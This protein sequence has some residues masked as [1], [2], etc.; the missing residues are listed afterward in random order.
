MQKSLPLPGSRFGLGLSVLLALSGWGL[1]A[2][3]AQP[4]LK[5]DPG[6]IPPNLRPLQ[7]EGAIGM[8]TKDNAYASLTQAFLAAQYAVEP[9]LGTRG[10]NGSAAFAASNPA[11]S[12]HATFTAEEV[13]VR[14][15]GARTWEVHFKLRGYGYGG[16]L[17]DLVGGATRGRENRIELDKHG[18]SDGA[19]VA[20][21]EWYEN[22]PSGLEQGFT[23]LAPPRSRAH[24]PGHLR[25]VLS[26]T[27]DLKP[28]VNGETRSLKLK[29]RAG[30]VLASYNHLKAWD[31]TGRELP[32]QMEVKGS[33]VSL[34]V[35]DASAKYP[36]T[37]DPTLEP[38]IKL[39]AP[40]SITSNQLGFAVAIS[41]S[42]AVIG[43]PNQNVGVQSH[44][45]MAYVF[46]RDGTGW[47]LQQ[48]L[49]AF[50]VTNDG[51]TTYY[52]GN[53]VG[54]SGNTIVVGSLVGTDATHF[55]ILHGEAHI[56]DR[57]GNH[58]S[59]RQKL[60]ADD[61]AGHDTFGESVAIT[62]DTVIIGSS[63]S[64]SAGDGS[65]EY[66][67]AA[68]IFGRDGEQWSKQ[69]KL[70]AS[71]GAKLDRF[72]Y[73]VSVSG[74]TA[75]VGA[76]NAG[77]GAAY[78]YGRSGVSWTQKKKLVPISQGAD[79]FGLSVGISG[80]NIFVGAPG[81]KVGQKTNQGAAYVSTRT[82]FVW[83]EPKQLLA[84]DGVAGDAFGESVAISGGTA[85]IGA[86]LKY[87]GGR[88]N[89]G[90]AY[91]YQQSSTG[92]VPVQEM[93]A[94]DGNTYQ[95][96]GQAVAVSGETLLIGAPGD[97][98]A[99][100]AAYIYETLDSDGDGIPDA[101]EINGITVGA[102]GNVVGL[103][104]LAGQGTFIDLKAMGADPMHKDIFV[105]ADWMHAASGS[106]TFKP[107]IKTMKVVTAAFAKAPVS[108]PDGRT[109]INLHVDLGAD[110]EMRPGQNW[111]SLSRAGEEPYVATLGSFTSDGGNPPVQVY[112]WSAFDGM[113]TD[114]F[115][116]SGR[117]AVFHYV[118]FANNY[119]GAKRSGGIARE[120]PSADI[121]VAMGQASGATVMQLGGTFMHELGHNLG[122]LHGGD[123]ETNFKPN[124][125]SIMN[126]TFQL[127][128]LVRSKNEQHVMDYSRR[129]LPILNEN[130]LDENVGIGEPAF[131]TFWVKPELNPGDF[132]YRLFQNG[133]LDWN[134]DGVQNVA[135]VSVD[136]TGDGNETLV[137]GFEDW[138]ALR[139]DG[140]GRIGNS[141]GADLGDRAATRMDEA[142]LTEVQAIV[143]PRI[144]NAEA[145]APD[146]EATIT[147]QEGPNSLTVTF[148]GSASTAVN[149]TIVSWAWDFGDGTTGTG[150]V[151]QHTY[152]SAGDYFATLTVTDSNGKINVIVLSYLVTVHLPP[153]PTPTPT[154]SPTPVPPPGPGQVDSTFMA[155]V[156]SYGGRTFNGNT[157]NAVITQPDGKIIVGGAFESFAGRARRNIARINAD[158]S[159]DPT[160]NPGLVLTDVLSSNKSPDVE[161]RN[162]LQ[163]HALKL[164]PDGKILVGVSGVQG[165]RAGVLYASKTLFRLNADG[166]LDPS[167]DAS[168]SLTYPNVIVL[169]I[170]LQTDGKIIIGGSFT[171]TNNGTRYDI[172]RLNADG[173]LDTSFMGGLG[174]LR[175]TADFA[176]DTYQ[177][178]AVQPD[179]KIIV[180]GHFFSDPN[181]HPGY[182]ATPILRINSNG[183]LDTTFNANRND[184]GTGTCGPFD[185]V[186]STINGL[187]LQSDGKIIAAGNLIS[188][189]RTSSSP[190]GRFNSDGS[191]D[192]LANG[193][194][195]NG[196]SGPGVG[197]ALQPD[198]KVIVVGSF[199]FGEPAT[200]I[201]VARLNADFTLDTSYNAGTGTLAPP[202]S[203]QRIQ[204]SVLAVA[205]QANGKAVI[206]GIFD[207]F[208]GALTEGIMQINPDGS[209]DQGFDSN[210]P[211]INAEVSALVRQPDG[212]LLVGF[213]GSS[214]GSNGDTPRNKLNSTRLGAIGRL[215][216]DGTTDTT[217][218]PPFDTGSG[219]S[220]IALQSDGKIVISGSFR[221]VGDTTTEGTFYLT[222]LNSNGTLDATFHPPPT[223]VPGRAVIRPDG[224]ILIYTPNG[225]PGLIRLNV[226]GS[227]D[228]TFSTEFFPNG[229]APMALQPDG[230]I[231][232][233]VAGRNFAPPHIGRLNADG[234]VDGTFDSGTGPDNA[235]RSLVL[236]PDGKI[237][238][239]GDFFNYN[240]TP[241][242]CMARLNADGSLD[243]S[244]IPDNPN[245]A[246]TNPTVPERVGA[247]ALQSD[248]KIFVGSYYRGDAF[249][250]SPN[251]IFR[252]N[253]NGSLD[254]S[255]PLGTGLEGQNLNVNAILL[256]QDGQ[257][258]IGG[259]FNIVNGAAHLALA[260]FIGA[261]PTVLANISTR[262]R[263]EAGDNALIGGFIITGTGQKKVLLRA[264]GPSLP[265]AGH[266]EDPVLELFAAN[267]QSIARNDNW[268]DATNRQEIIDSTIPPTND[269]ESAILT[270]LNPGA[271]TAIM[272]GVSDTSGIGV[273]EAYDLDI[274]AGSKL[275]NI[276][277]RG[278]V[279]TDDGV[280]IAGTIVLGQATQK[281]IVRAIGPS[282]TVPG[283]LE[284]PTLQL[285]NQQGTVLAEND[286]WVD[287]PDKQAI[288]DST[289]AP[290][291]NLESAIMAT[292]PSGGAQYTAIV[293]GVSNTTGVAVVDVFALN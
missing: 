185:P 92:W 128:G 71:D 241:R 255:F 284:D 41:G 89:Q 244:F 145:G 102:D 78:I 292:L 273:V 173:S 113:K 158:G 179:G 257:A 200:R 55:Q 99:K 100:G 15:A 121:I 52:F 203:G 237:L 182:C 217:F 24:A 172:A 281:V 282:L 57:S 88:Q 4:D 288:I 42:T 225:T 150:A 79:E 1:A 109:G 250:A 44:F 96:F 80:V 136:I 253:Q 19:A 39:V 149:G 249:Y 157:I 161:F 254:S 260:R 238:I 214:G 168:A 235:V 215:N 76:F 206:G 221:L 246:Q 283:K 30:T 258:I 175:P 46:A 144:L 114:Y 264:I 232:I 152:S 21:T 211:G 242:N 256:Q 272:R 31:A 155:T 45:G 210:G 112:N 227:R 9:A 191:R 87:V 25:V 50:D 34:E 180:G 163:V 270:N 293:R 47:S 236:Q 48:K 240:G 259:D 83:S 17:V 139:F 196:Q 223:G 118:L 129:A 187:A 135:P 231:I 220:Y 205:L 16:D 274:T 53:S 193:I 138:S 3:S 285:V 133:A 29:D 190:A 2:P 167:F 289:V 33:E 22:K 124:Y 115:T 7:G 122:L 61:G 189:D 26:V 228:D 186:L 263:V 91:V 271:Y 116:P 169:A 77:S 245:T 141:A 207:H 85:V 286:N 68:F 54:I 268:N 38:E 165:W 194:G 184:P 266:L 159:C 287:S 123:E 201:G 12:L 119:D 251:R 233:L 160:F 106:S 291:N 94:T 63:L 267:G 27:G 154:P 5:S 164:Q 98:S 213:Y 170:A 8:L 151:T 35:D 276:S 248:G 36:I 212:K 20:V 280:L 62:G 218:T 174:Y 188:P 10:G 70:L 142:P 143:P 130:S 275:A 127:E 277:T 84:N 265:I 49:T 110:R 125:L 65:R 247:L 75:V 198:G 148:D 11:L 82:N 243:T 37:I 72:G 234:A 239:G 107:S 6:P 224:K 230:R 95:V 126:Y 195:S 101:W 14:S 137:T 192:V 105:H 103:G 279:Q 58:W 216:P 13:C 23:I 252:L 66:Q 290:T 183:S 108:N 40:A 177:A 117:R 176:H 219:V 32:A 222:R 178:F 43:S 67:G 153:V 229:A 73:S 156:T 208:N 64:D 140:G 278:L 147:T 60:V 104:N 209:P 97:N 261:P 81:T 28:E 132:Y 74:D 199:R 93:A 59:A 262:L 202:N 131:Y 90:V 166:T 146:D 56:F 51:Y 181:L 269:L 69:A 197:V 226:D 171:Y 134:R 86:H 162:D 111:G 120:V 204:I 18:A